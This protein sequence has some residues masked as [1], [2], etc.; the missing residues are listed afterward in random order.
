LETT[1]PIKSKGV[2]MDGRKGMS[3]HETH[4]SNLRYKLLCAQ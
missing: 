1:N 2:P 4:A 3:T